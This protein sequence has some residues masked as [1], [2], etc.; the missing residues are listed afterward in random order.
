MRSNA[1]TLPFA[2][3]RS[4]SLRG[5]WRG[6]ELLVGN[7]SF[8]QSRSSFLTLW[9][10]LR[11]ARAT[12]AT[13]S[14]ATVRGLKALGPYG[15]GRS[16]LPRFMR[17]FGRRALVAREVT[18]DDSLLARHVLNGFLQWALP[19]GHGW[20]PGNDHVPSV[21]PVA[22]W[23]HEP[24]WCGTSVCRGS[25]RGPGCRN[26]VS[27]DQ[28]RRSRDLI[29]WLAVFT[30]IP[31]SDGTRQTLAQCLPSVVVLV[32]RS[33]RTNFSLKSRTAP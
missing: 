9:Y 15:R 2:P 32:I 18:H 16:G 10:R 17:V 30:W 21:H 5:T 19:S 12:F 11:C 4:A 29:A 27:A 7:A 20:P 24:S 28:V 33:R 26:E 1:A 13:M 25:G 14:R 31:S 3:S 6:A 23:P 8:S 22:S